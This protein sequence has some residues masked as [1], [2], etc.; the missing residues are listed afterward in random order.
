[1]PSVVR[2][3]GESQAP[4]WLELSVSVDREAVDDIA[5][6][7]GRF[8]HGGA[9]IEEDL[10]PQSPHREKNLAV[11]AYLP[12]DDCLPQRKGQLLESLGHLSLICP[13]TVLERTLSQEDWIE[14]WK[15]HF[16]PKRVGERLVIKP[17]WQNYEAR[18]GDVV[19]EIDPGMAFGTG[20]HPT[21]RLCLRELERRIRPGME[22]LDLGT[23]SGIQAIAAAKLGAARVL[24]LD[25]DPEAVKAAQAH[26]LTNGLSAVVAVERGTIPHPSAQRPFD[27]VVANITAG[28]IGE[29]AQN[30]MAALKPQGVLIAGGILADREGEVR[31]RL[32]RAGGRIIQRRAQGDWRTLVVEP[33]IPNKEAKV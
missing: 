28:V 14:A 31:A 16:S 12:V 27:L 29:L 24:A 15:A 4:K 8:G 6:I 23:G 25:T 21:T 22:V 18:D 7:L 30:L 13:I 9:V 11:K 17:S 19:I 26:V 20:L 10:S 1:M 32:A 33:I 2:T 5:D 3:E